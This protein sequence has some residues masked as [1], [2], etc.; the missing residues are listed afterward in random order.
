MK[1]GKKHPS[2]QPAAGNSL[3]SQMEAGS[4]P[5]APD[6]A[7][8]ASLRQRAV[9]GISWNFAA[10]FGNQF[11]QFVLGVL[12][13][14]KLSPDDFG[15]MG[16]IAIFVTL[17]RVLADGGLGSALI[18][19]RD[20]DEI[21]A[22][23]VFFLNLA[24]SFGLAG[25]LCLLALPVAAFYGQPILESLMYAMA[26]GPVLTAVGRVHA[27]FLTKKMEFGTLF[28]VSICASLLSGLVGLAGAW[29]GWGV[30][31]LV[32]M[33]LSN[34]AIR[35]AALWY[36]HDWHPRLV[37][38]VR[39]IREMAAV[40][41]PLLGSG[42]I[43]AVAQ[44]VNSLVIGKLYTAADVGLYTRARGL[45]RLPIANLTAAVGSVSFPA[46]AE[47]QD[48]LPRIRRGLR[49]AIRLLAFVV[50][51]LVGFITGSATAL[52]TVLLTEKWLGCVPLLRL[53][54]FSELL[55]PLTVLN[56]NVLKARGEAS[57][58]FRLSLVKQTLAF[59]ILAVTCRI[60]IP[61]IVIGQVVAAF[62]AYLLNSYYSGKVLAYHASE[63]LADVAPF[64]W[65]AALAGGAAYAWEWS[66]V[67]P[68][69]LLLLFQG[70][71]AVAVYGAGCWWFGVP[72]LQ[73]VVELVRHRLARRRGEASMAERLAAASMGDVVADGPK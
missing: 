36:L 43:D 12:I 20:A 68:A 33:A 32:W 60:S 38:S 7:T 13:A 72:E 41:V 54:C 19:K 10:G 21:D 66:G 26:V 65:M 55:F 8:K 16:M 48:D 49:Q 5:F 14:R 50:F 30:W 35:S 1:S 6:R 42:I 39:S 31:S 25:L 18:Q 69:W 45:Q 4:N 47:V 53:M 27:S 51:P 44:N 23:S 46:F 71:T 56:L 57:L 2:D 63:Q 24:A 11:V 40:G 64:A 34:E 37:F 17:M 58:F 9:H 3:A 52:I 59:A 70:L 62:L 29:A 15:L 61:L 73:Q 67:G 22:S 28:R